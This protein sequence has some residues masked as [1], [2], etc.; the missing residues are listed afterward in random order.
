MRL[1]NRNNSRALTNDEAFLS[2]MSAV[3]ND[4]TYS[5]IQAM[6][7]SDI[8]TAVR[9]IATDISS[10]PI[11]F[12]KDD[13]KTPHKHL[14]HL[15]NV[16]PNPRMTAYSFKYALVAN[17]LLNGESF[18]RIR[19]DDETQQVTSLELIRNSDISVYTDGT[20]LTY[21]VNETIYGSDNKVVKQTQVPLDQSEVL[22]FKY[23]SLDGLRGLSP[24]TALQQEIAMIDQ[25]NKTLLASFK[26]GVTGSGILTVDKAKLDADTKEKIREDFE[27]ANSGSGNVQRTIIMDSTMSYV[28]LEMNTEI[29]KLVNSNTWQSAQIAKVFGL[30]L[31]KFGQEMVNT[32][33]EASNQNYVQSSLTGYIQALASELTSK[34]L[35]VGQKFDFNT[36][37]ITKMTE[38]QRHNTLIN[39][40]DKG[41]LTPNEVRKELGYPPIVNGDKLVGDSTPQ[42]GESD[43]RP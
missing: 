31:D 34:L 41:I 10:S 26:K 4:S 19:Y 37:N 6:Q 38:E 14:N 20:I 8:F 22:H 42:G 11:E 3:T 16:Q 28:P 17:M 15:L 35:E 7:S 33:T 43:E 23:M 40:K 9:I 2:F 25:G 13:Q 27:R 29:L 21:R 24:L 32:S 39:G 36:G 18:A 5:P 30:P 12:Y 1:F